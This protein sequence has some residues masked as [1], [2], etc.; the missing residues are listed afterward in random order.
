MITRF[1]KTKRIK[2]I[3]LTNIYE[4]NRENLVKD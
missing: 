1:P 2:N 4:A 3:I